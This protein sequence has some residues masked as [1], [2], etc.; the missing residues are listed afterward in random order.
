MFTTDINTVF[1]SRDILKTLDKIS[2]NEKKTIS[3]IPFGSISE[4]F[5]IIAKRVKSNKTIEKIKSRKGIALYKLE[6]YDRSSG[7]LKD[8]GYFIIYKMPGYDFLYLLITLEESDFFHRDVRPFIKSFYKDV[9]LSFTKSNDL[10]SLIENYQ[11]R[12]GLSEIKIT[13]ASQKIRY[14]DESSMSTV[15]WNNS[16][17]DEAYQWLRENNGFFKSIQFKAFQFDF[18][19]S[20]TFI[21][22]RGI[23]RVDRNFSKVFDA[24]IMPNFKVLENYIRLFK[25]R[26]RRDNDLLDVK[27]LEINFQDEVF[28]EKANH[29]NFIQMLSLLND[30][31]I[32]VLHGNPYIH[33]SI[34]DYID[35]SSYDI[36]VLDSK[37]LLLVPQLR[38]SIISLKVSPLPTPSMF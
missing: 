33:L 3:L 5:E 13:R 7:E 11:S 29:K 8:S 25:N 2:D 15:T 6:K 23:V 9:I 17:L 1:N 32:S 35:A 4:I 24:L 20:N 27:P 18:E 16:S 21:D 12:N 14:H 19:V 37:Q 34:I 36:W 28:K 30:T 22:R 26:G 31:S 10:I 38:S